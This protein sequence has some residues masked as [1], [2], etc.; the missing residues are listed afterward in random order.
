M[1][2]LDHPRRTV[3]VV[4][5]CNG[6]GYEAY[7]RRMAETFARHWP[8]EIPLLLYCEGFEPD[9]LGDRIVVRDLIASAPGLAAFKG[10]HAD[11][12]LANGLTRRHR[13]R[14][15][16]NPD[17]MRLKLGEK[18]WGEGY[19]WNAVRF[20]HKVFAIVH[21]AAVSDA[22]VLIWIDAD[23]RFFADVTWDE[24][25]GF[26]PA[27]R[28][29]GYLKRRIH[30]ECGFTAY[31]LRHPATREMLAAL[32]RLYTHDELF[33]QYEFHDSYLFDIVRKRAE[34]AGHKSFDIAG[35]IGLEVPHVLI[36]SRLGR[37][38]DHLKGDRKDGGKSRPEDR[39]LDR[40]EAYWRDPG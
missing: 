23:T 26:V 19:R 15:S 18:R 33:R 1:P 10:R 28:F 9:G 27:D 17:K 36:N 20:A 4:T 30:S 5:T 12:P 25:E 29:V 21:A 37:F 39:V 40:G 3:S 38:M 31:N 2:R 24:I 32:E 34:R 14:L 7:G 22:D 11:N 8:V 6:A 35:G 16:F 13:F